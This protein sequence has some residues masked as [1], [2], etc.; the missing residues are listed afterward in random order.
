MV[1]PSDKSLEPDGK[2]SLAHTM[3]VRSHQAYLPGEQRR[4][5][6]SATNFSYYV[7]WPVALC[8]NGSFAHTQVC[9][10]QVCFLREEQ[11]SVLKCT[12]LY[13]LYPLGSVD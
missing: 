10:I 13:Y 12:R 2:G 4:C 11:T 7:C 9:S 8:G 6:E 3:Y 5:V 1:F